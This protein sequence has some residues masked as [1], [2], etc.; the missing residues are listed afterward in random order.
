MIA[1]CLIVIGIIIAC[2]AKDN[3]K[4]TLAFTGSVILIILILFP[5]E[6]Y[7]KPQCVSEQ[8]LVALRLEDE[9]EKTYYIIEGQYGKC[10]YALDKSDEYGLEGEAYKQEE[11]SEPLV[12]SLEIYESKDCTQP[13]L[14]TYK[15]RPYRGT[16]AI[17]PFSTKTKYVFYVPEGTVRYYVSEETSS[18]SGSNSSD[19]NIEESSKQE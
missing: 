6:G 17:A 11:K 19:S 1:I 8:P 10:T 5:I 7:S 12:G 16:F 3:W 4:I 14:K 13:I 9:S 2:T 15:T 18:D